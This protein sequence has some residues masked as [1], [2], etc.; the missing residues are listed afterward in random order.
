M[1]L[2][3]SLLAL[4]QSFLSFVD[5]QQPQQ[6]V[7]EQVVDVSTASLPNPPTFR[8]PASSDP[9][10]V[11]VALCASSDN[12]NR[13]FVTNDTTQ[14][15]PGP[16]DVDAVNTVEL[17]LSDG[18]V[19]TRSSLFN[20][21]GVLSVLK[22]STPVEFQVLVS[23]SNST[24][25]DY[26]FLGDTT[27]NQALIF[28]P[29]F[30][31]VPPVDPTFPNYTLPPANLTFPSPPSP[32]INYTLVFA[33]TS[34]KNLSS[35]PRTSC[36]LKSTAVANGA[37]LLPPAASE[38]LWLR[39]ADGWR[40]QWLVNGLNPRTN[41]TL[42]AFRDG[43]LRSSPP[44]YFLT[45]SAAF[46]CPLVHSLPF[47]P[48]VGY[49]VPLAAP[50]GIT[51]AHTAATIPGTPLVTCA[52]CQDAY[53][54]WLCVVSFPRCGESPNATITTT[55]TTSTTPAVAGGGAQVPLPALQPV[56]AGAPQR[57]PVLPPFASAYEA[58]LPCLETCNAADR[59][60]PNFLG[61]KCPLPRFTAGE[62]YGVGYIDAGGGGV[63]GGG[64]TGV[65]QD[66]F[67]N[68]WCNRG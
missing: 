14:S 63:V 33:P 28:S 20:N 62:S 36:A 59:A 57:N 35:L 32:P 39:D 23:A 12:T 40:W 68:V 7:L 47:C 37:T 30:A 29:P 5:A 26:P 56:K 4:I 17:D 1:L 3:L 31:P 42:F 67:G 19:A 25:P 21:G 61:F 58:L 51:T 41:Y 60:C 55:A 18:G 48:T 15:D 46:N 9:L 53:R 66:V 38:G 65:A 8:I 34:S 16:S 10:F 49:A 45:K 54:R 52:D 24:A 22:G 13:F 11:T 64:V 2:P 27:S 50:G 6:L 43:E 44:A